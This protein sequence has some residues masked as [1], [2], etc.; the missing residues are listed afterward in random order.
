M[1]TLCRGL[2]AG[3]SGVWGLVRDDGR[4]LGWVGSGVRCCRNDCQS[5]LGKGSK[6]QLGCWVAMKPEG[7]FPALVLQKAGVLQD[8]AVS[9]VEDQ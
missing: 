8:S 3:P 4:H 7:R 1:D 9:T 5:P 6:D 2:H